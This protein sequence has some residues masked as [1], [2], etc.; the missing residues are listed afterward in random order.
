LWRKLA[1]MNHSIEETKKK[2]DVLKCIK[3]PKARFPKPNE[4][5]Y[6]FGG[7]ICDIDK[8]NVGKYDPCRFG[9]SIIQVKEM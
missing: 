2:N 5:C 7:L 1:V 4:Q 3:C 8:E 9:Y 6:K